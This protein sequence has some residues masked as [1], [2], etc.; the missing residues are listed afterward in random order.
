[1]K[2][3]EEDRAVGRGRGGGKMAS[4]S[5][6]AHRSVGWRDAVSWGEVVSAKWQSALVVE[7]RTMRDG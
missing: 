1:M 5:G 6:C 3:Q 4:A 2:N 7:S